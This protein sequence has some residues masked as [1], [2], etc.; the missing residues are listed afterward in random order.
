MQ[1]D[2]W[3]ASAQ[4]PAPGGC[5]GKGLGGGGGGGLGLGGGGGGGSGNGGGG[6]GGGGDG[7]KGTSWKHLCA[8]CVSSIQGGVRARRSRNADVLVDEND[9]WHD[10]GRRHQLNWKE[11][12]GR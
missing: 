3:L 4:L 1:V 12:L 9:G 6:D 10:G 2:P 8:L 7:L 11:V 5:G